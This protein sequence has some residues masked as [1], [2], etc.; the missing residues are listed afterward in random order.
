MTI[1]KHSNMQSS[2]STILLPT[3]KSTDEIV[4]DPAIM[5]LPESTFQC[6]HV[7]FKRTHA[8]S[9]IGRT[10]TPERILEVTIQ[11]NEL[12]DSVVDTEYNSNI[13][14]SI[15]N[16]M[17]SDIR[18]MF[19]IRNTISNYITTGDIMTRQILQLLKA[20]LISNMV[21]RSR[22]MSCLPSIYASEFKNEH[23]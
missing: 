12:F 21:S 13:L 11:L 18:N 6:E 20:S 17:S 22:S 7:R 1:L 5:C 19:G 9:R 10:I 8:P 3:V 23:M 16:I 15:S 14:E 4:Y 2:V